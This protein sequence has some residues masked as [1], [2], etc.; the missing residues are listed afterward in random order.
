L[1]SDD[2]TTHLLVNRA[3]NRFDET[4]SGGKEE[5]SFAYNTAKLEANYTPSITQAFEAGVAAQKATIQIDQTQQSGFNTTQQTNLYQ[6]FLNWNWHIVPRLVLNTGVYSQ[7]I[8]YDTGSSYEPR[9]SLAWSATD[10]HTFAVAF[11]VHRQPEPLQFTQAL[12]Y[13]AGYTFR[14]AP[15][16]LLK[17]EGYYKDYSHVPVHASTKDSYSFLNEG[18]AQRIDYYDLV[19]SGVGRSYGAELTFMKHY[20]DGYYVTATTSFV[21][22]QFVGSD[23]VWRF[24]SFD[25]IYIVNLLAGYDISLGANSVLTL[26]EKFT[27]AGGG[28]YTPFDLQQSAA[29]GYEVLD[30]AH[31]FS[32]RNPPYVRADLNAELH[33]NWKASTLTV[34]LSI[35]N[36]LN[37]KNPTNRYV[38][39]TNGVPEIKEDYDLPILPIVGIRFEF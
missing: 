17:A 28:T 6:A 7:F 38:R 37:I 19:S 25:N 30:S 15:D 13:V 12:H 24:G 2:F 4:I 32:A 1:F 20:G 14:P 3:T 26:S 5:I 18:F 27:I 36:V 29:S 35:L 21:R 22:Q 9:I 11:G 10:E 23:G 31:A 33:I 16:I 34:Y 39:F 8:T